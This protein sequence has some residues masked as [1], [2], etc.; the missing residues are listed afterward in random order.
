[1]KSPVLVL[2]ANFEPIHVCST[3]RAISLILTGKADLVMN[4]RGEIR[5]VS[6]SYPRPTIIRLGHMV[7]R[8][9][10]RVKL[11]KREILSC[12]G[13]W[14]ATIHGRTWSLHAL[15]VTTAKGG[16]PWNRRTCLSFATPLNPRHQPCTSLPATWS[17]TRS[18]RLLSRD[19]NKLG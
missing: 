1:L 10:P 17:K 11:T 19:G 9:R 18:G 13:T 4:G 6:R 12:P 5:T 7:H 8:P 15:L 3:H 2:N 16:A 14:G